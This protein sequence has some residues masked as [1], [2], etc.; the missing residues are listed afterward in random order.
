M[1]YR[2]GDPGWG[3]GDRERGIWPKTWARKTFFDQEHSGWISPY[4]QLF[5]IV[6]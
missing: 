5:P 3:G 1:Q 6:G 4:L 2:K